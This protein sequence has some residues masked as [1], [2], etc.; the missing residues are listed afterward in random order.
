[1]KIKRSVGGIIYDDQGKI[2]LSESPKWNA[3]VV[4]GG[5]M[6]AGETEEQTLHREIRE[7]MGIEI[8]RLVKVGEKVKEPST[9]SFDPEL[10]F[11]FIDYFAHALSTNVTPN[12]EITNYGWFTVE[13]A[14]GMNLLDAT[15]HL[16]LQ[17]QQYLKE[18]DRHP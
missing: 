2:F 9:D 18:Q 5:A 11:E 12:D 3:W 13:E 17:Y 7:E 14:L 16:V 10:K 4:Q 15:R 1:M 6:E 8:D